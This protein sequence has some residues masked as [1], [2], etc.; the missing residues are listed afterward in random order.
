MLKT[1]FIY[2]KDSQGSA[3]KNLALCPVVAVESKTQISLILI[4]ITM[5]SSKHKN[6]RWRVKLKDVPMRDN[7]CTKKPRSQN[8]EKNKV[9][10]QTK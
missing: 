9:Q 1:M 10:T 6:S 3:T 2:R 7:L 5:A 4:N 8:T